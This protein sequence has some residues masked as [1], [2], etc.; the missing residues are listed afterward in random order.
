MRILIPSSSSFEE[1]MLTK[2][3]VF[4]AFMT[5]T[6]AIFGTQVFI[7]YIFFLKFQNLYP[8]TKPS[9]ISPASCTLPYRDS[10]YLP[11]PLG[12]NNVRK[13]E[14][15]NTEKNLAL[16]LLGFFEG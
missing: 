8:N 7:S 16:K 4:V 10:S 2:P 14:E 1:M 9:H 11:A 3:F 12:C 5:L 6:A 15:F 13:T